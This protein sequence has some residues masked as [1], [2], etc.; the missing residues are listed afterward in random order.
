MPGLP[1]PRAI[2]PIT[3][4]VIDEIYLESVTVYS[5]IT[6]CKSSVAVDHFKDHIAC[7]ENYE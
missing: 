5:S 7:Y 1:V 3:D 4:E 2:G 6:D